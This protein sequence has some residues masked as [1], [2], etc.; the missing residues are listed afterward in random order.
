MK[1][2]WDEQKAKINLKKHKISF[3]NAKEIFCDSF[4]LSIEDPDN[5]L[6]EDRWIT[7]GSYTGEI[8]ITVSHIFR[9]IKGEDIIRIISAR[10]ATS[11]EKRNYYNK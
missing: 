7:I 6:E 10:K 2:E 3:E 11:R 8:I 4:H 5:S 9:D 1:Y